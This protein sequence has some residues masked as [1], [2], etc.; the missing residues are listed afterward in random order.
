M[1]WLY[2]EFGNIILVI[3][4]G[5]KREVQESL[6]GKSWRRG[7]TGVEPQIWVLVQREGVFLSVL[8]RAPGKHCGPRLLAPKSIQPRGSKQPKVGNT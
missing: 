5:S 2:Q 4:A 8:A 1:P 3:T 6:E 7:M